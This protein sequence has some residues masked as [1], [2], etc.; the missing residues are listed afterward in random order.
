MNRIGAFILGYAIGSVLTYAFIMLY[1]KALEKG[2]KEVLIKRGKEKW[3][4]R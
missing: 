3:K 2:Y 4:S 1:A